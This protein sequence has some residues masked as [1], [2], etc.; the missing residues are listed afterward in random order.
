M[1]RLRDMLA[2]GRSGMETRDR[3]VQPTIRAHRWLLDAMLEQFP[4]GSVNVFDRD[5][6]YLYAA[7]T[8][9]ARVGLAPAG[10]IGMR[11]DDLY[12]ADAVALVRPFY[13]RAFAGE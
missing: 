6:R 1:R 5:F 10:L 8:G 12:P 2:S 3:S 4:N 9:L 11:L 13:D 7:G